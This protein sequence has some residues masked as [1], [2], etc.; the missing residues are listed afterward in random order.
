MAHLYSGLGKIDF[1]RHFFPHKDVRIP[2]FGEQRLQ[3]VEL[4]ARK[5]SPFS[6]L[7]PWCSCKNK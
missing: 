6:P 5:S 4:C 7:F 1:Q 3:H 2:R